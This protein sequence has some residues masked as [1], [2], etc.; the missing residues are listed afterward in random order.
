MPFD[1]HEF[2]VATA[3]AV[4]EASSEAFKEYV[5]VNSLLDDKAQKTAGLAG[6]FLAAAVAF[7]K[8][9]SLSA[10]P[11]NRLRVL[12]PLMLT[13]V[14]LI[15]CVGFCL[16]VIWARRVPGLPTIA[17]LEKLKNDLA[18][19]PDTALQSYEVGYWET[20][21]GVWRSILDE[22]GLYI[23]AKSRKLVTAQI[24]LAVCML[25]VGFVLLVILGPIL[26][27]HLK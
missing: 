21:S 16:A 10:W 1:A 18:K 7:I 11:L 4:A 8:I 25:T 9:D 2:R 5:R 24:L 19:I 6:A 17:L 20:R 23:S 27:T 15:F 3:R 14:L 13:I 22:H 26:W 12:I